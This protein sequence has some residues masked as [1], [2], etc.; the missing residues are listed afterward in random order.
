LKRKKLVKKPVTSKGPYSLRDVNAILGA[1][2]AVRECRL[3]YPECI[4]QKEFPVVAGAFLYKF[5]VLC[6]GD[7]VRLIAREPVP[8]KLLKD[9]ARQKKHGHAPSK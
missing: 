1:A 4:Q 8:K 6:R 5:K 2:E 3:Q 9:F 7:G